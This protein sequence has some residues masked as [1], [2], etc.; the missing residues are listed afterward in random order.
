VGET[1]KRKKK[2]KKKKKKKKKT[3]GSGTGGVQGGIPTKPVSGA[4]PL[5]RHGCSQAEMSV[6]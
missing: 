5:D 1:V 3:A 6:P 2:N 4:R